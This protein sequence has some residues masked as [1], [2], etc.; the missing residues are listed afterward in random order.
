MSCSPMWRLLT[1]HEN[2]PRLDLCEIE[3]LF[4]DVHTI[5]YWQKAILLVQVAQAVCNAHCFILRSQDWFDVT[6]CCLE[7]A[8][9]WCTSQRSSWNP[10]LLSMRPNTLP[11]LKWNSPY[12][13]MKILNRNA[14]GR[15][16]PFFMCMCSFQI[17]ECRVENA[18]L[19]LSPDVGNISP[20][21]TQ[22]NQLLC[23]FL[24]CRGKPPCDGIVVLA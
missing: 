15:S 22:W 18:F 7:K 3:P 20:R 17:N 13:T 1:W 23:N 4:V 16:S 10:Y 2:V 9:F 6:L 24:I 5:E 19:M 8:K 12:G 21:N 11:T 14:S